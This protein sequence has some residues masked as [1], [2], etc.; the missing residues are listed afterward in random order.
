MQEKIVASKFYW[1]AKDEDDVMECG[2]KESN[3]GIFT[4]LKQDPQY[5]SSF[6][7]TFHNLELKLKVAQGGQAE[8]FEAEFEKENGIKV[9][10]VVKIFDSDFSLSDMVSNGHLEY[11][12]GDGAGHLVHKGMDSWDFIL[13]LRGLVKCWVH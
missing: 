1:T 5:L 9:P 8:I 12:G 11:A 6:R 7:N 10:F 4:R 13:A 3:Q 2:R